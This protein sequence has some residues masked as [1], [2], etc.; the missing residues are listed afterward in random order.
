MD[1]RESE[2]ASS[3]RFARLGPAAAVRQL[4]LSRVVTAAGFGVV[5]LLVLGYGAWYLG[6]RAVGWVRHQEPYW[7]AFKEIT[8]SPP[9]PA[10]FRGGT[11]AFLDH[12]RTAAMVKTDRVPILDGDPAR[13]ALAFQKSPWVRRVSQVR[14]AYPRQLVVKLEYREPVARPA[15][16]PEWLVDRDGV[17]L[18]AS[19]VARG[20]VSDLVLLEH[21]GRPYD[22]RP[23]Q[24]W[25]V[26]DP[27]TQRVSE[28]PRAT[29]A[30]RLA[31]FLRSPDASRDGDIPPKVIAV[32][33]TTSENELF[34]QFQKATRVQWGKPPG[35]EGPDEPSATEKWHILRDW[36][37]KHPDGVGPPDYLARTG[38]TF[39]IQH[40]PPSGPTGPLSRSSGGSPQSLSR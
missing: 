7:I 26:Y 34:L 39:V 38:R 17:I 16:L 20:V 10:W 37:R 35:S 5:M 3:R 8:L 2:S 36:F 21:L 15:E 9:P 14:R 29:A 32:L 30:G 31:A 24:A 4:A 25:Q 33:L 13:L 22:P 27:A 28:E 11:P 1:H 23:G 40:D 12:V 6:A 18:P 19:D